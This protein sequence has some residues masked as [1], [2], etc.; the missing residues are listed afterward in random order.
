MLPTAAFKTKLRSVLPHDLLYSHDMYL[1]NMG[2]CL[3]VLGLSSI[4]V[5][6]ALPQSVLSG[7]W[8]LVHTVTLD[9]PTN[10]VQG[11]EFDADSLWVTSVDSTNRKGY[12]RAFSITSGNLAKG[13]EVQ[14]G[15]RFHPGGIAADA[16]SL[17]FPVAEYRPNSASIIQMRNKRTLGLEFSFNV[18][19]HIGCIA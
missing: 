18:S 16:E 3:S 5:V 4:F 13:I 12:L 2:L 14:Q 11:I 6:D 1:R 8:K 17:W 9:G 15:E 19:D 7:E 10:H